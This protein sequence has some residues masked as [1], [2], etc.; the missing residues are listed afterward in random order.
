MVENQFPAQYGWIC[1]RCGKVLAPWMP[2]CNCHKIEK[3]IKTEKDIQ[4]I[5]KLYHNFSK[6]SNEKNTGE[7]WLG[8]INGNKI[9]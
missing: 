5:E 8:N 1:L 3:E 2:E 7:D 4:T 6:I 9:E